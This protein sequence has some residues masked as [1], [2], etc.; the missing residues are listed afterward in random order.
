MTERLRIIAGDALAVLKTLPDESVQMCVTSPPYWVLRDYGIA[1]QLGL[2][3]TPEEYISR[4]VEVFREVRRVLRSDGTCWV[5][6]GDAYAQGGKH[7]SAEETERARPNIEY[8][9]SIRDDSAGIYKVP[10]GWAERGDRAAKTSVS[11]LKPKDLCGIPWRLAFA[12]Q[13][14]GWWLRQDIIW[15]KV[16]PMPE[17]VQ[18]RCC[19]SHEYIFL[20]SKSSRYFFDQEAIKEPCSDST[21]ARI[22]QNLAAQVGSF[23]ANGGNKTNGPMKAVI[24]GSTRKIAESGSGIAANESYEASRALVVSTRTKRSV[25]RVTTEGY[26]EAHFATYPPDLIK[27]CILAGTSARGCCPKC[28][29]P[30]ERVTESVREF[31][32]PIDNDPKYAHEF[33]KMAR[34]KAGLVGRPIVTECKTT[35]WRPTCTCGETETQ[36]CVVLDPFFGSGT[37]GQVALELGRHCIGIEL[38]PA[39]LKLAERR[40]HVT[41]GLALA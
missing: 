5:N 16:N 13:A 24:A 30:W 15:D 7:M 28:G 2:E 34:T 11:G 4:M 6:M 17:S 33:N 40:C 3:R 23:R 10:S 9:K 18:D 1:G 12:L 29:A 32:R 37:T 14:D 39:Y 41:P 27:P 31:T 19:K 26:S 36:P 22:S 8:R 25:W 35:G 20:L 38:N 21:H